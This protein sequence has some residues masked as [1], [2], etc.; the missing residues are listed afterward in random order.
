MKNLKNNFLLFYAI[1]WILV[2][3]GPYLRSISD[4][5]LNSWTRMIGDWANLFL[6]LAVF[7]VNLWILVPKLLFKSL[8]TRPVFS[9]VTKMLQNPRVLGLWLSDPRDTLTLPT[10]EEKTWWSCPFWARAPARKK[11][12]TL[13][14]WNSIPTG[15]YA[16]NCVSASWHGVN[17][18]RNRAGR[19]DAHVVTIIK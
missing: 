19:G 6:L 17:S 8:Q 15:R 4:T 2:F 14:T 11:I 3:L 18:G 16:A 12:S 5:D 7:I 1:I 13:P 10:N 9:L